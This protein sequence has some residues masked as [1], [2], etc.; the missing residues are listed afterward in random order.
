[1]GLTVS[2]VRDTSGKIVAALKIIRD[3]TERK[4]TESQ[5]EL[6][7]DLMPTMCWMADA[8]GWIFWYNRRWYEYTGT[9][10]EQMRGWGWQHV[11]DP[12]PCRRC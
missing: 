11:H 1:M 7:A 12:Q 8:E 9:T 4:R 5:F 6:L 10:F 2:P 3:I